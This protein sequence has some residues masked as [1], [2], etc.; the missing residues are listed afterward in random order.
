MSP[1]SVSVM[2]AGQ[3]PSPEAVVLLDNGIGRLAHAWITGHPGDELGLTSFTISPSSLIDSESTNLGEGIFGMVYECG[4]A[5]DGSDRLRDGNTGNATVV[6]KKLSKMVSARVAADFAV[7]AA[8]ME[9]L[10]HPNV[11]RVLGSVMDCEP[12]MVIF[13]GHV[14]GVLRTYLHSRKTSSKLS[15]LQQAR[16]SC[17]V[18]AGLDYLHES[19]SVHRD[20]A[21]RNCLVTEDDIVR[22]GDFGLSQITFP[23]DYHVVQGA[24]LPVRWMAPESFRELFWEISCHGNHPFPKLSSSE[25]AAKVQAGGVNVALKGC[26]KTLAT[27]IASCQL[28]N[29]TKRPAASTLFATL[30]KLVESLAESAAAHPVASGRSAGSTK[31][32]TSG[33]D[34]S[35][36]SASAVGGYDD[37]ADAITVASTSKGKTSKS[38]SRFSK[39]KS[40]KKSFRSL[41]QFKEAENPSEALGAVAS[42][43]KAVELDSARLTLSSELGQGAFGVVVKGKLVLDDGSSVACACKTLKDRKNAEDLDALEAE[44]ELVSQ[45]D[46]ENVVKCFGKVT[47]VDPA[48]IVFEFMSNGSLYGYLQSLPEVPKLQRMMQ[49]AIDVAT[50]MAYLAGGNNVHRDLATR[51]VLVNEELTCKISDFGLSRDLDDDTY[52]ESDG[53]MVP[54]RWTPPEAYKYKK[55]STSS[56]VWSYG[57]TLYEVWTKGGLPYGRKW[58]NMNVMIEVE[59]GYRLPAPAKCPKAVYQ[60]MLKCWNPLRKMRPAFSSIQEQLQMAYDMMFPLEEELPTE[61]E[62][63]VDTEYGDMDQMYYGMDVP[64][65]EDLDTYL[66]NPTPVPSPVKSS[67]K[68]AAAALGDELKT[69]YVGRDIEQK[70]DRFAH[71]LKG[72]VGT[73][74]NVSGNQGDNPASSDLRASPLALRKDGETRGSLRKQKAAGGGEGSSR[75]TIDVSAGTRVADMINLSKAKEEQSAAELTGIAKLERSGES[76]QVV[77]NFYVESVGRAV[78]QVTEVKVGKRKRCVCR[79]FKCVCGAK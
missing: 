56:D 21:A 39:L 63:E 38:T 35:A 7:E 75:D 66:E 5:R 73:N 15:A 53:G 8:A 6:V 31:S 68:S 40:T 12:R 59:K 33:H 22:I 14:H 46:H 13:E 1:G 34:L 16:M 64:D 60:L 29:P 48:M 42:K 26:N 24:T 25:V 72:N 76:S 32:T 28:A 51:N 9:K 65:E 67:V 79:R 20:L 11:L 17:D 50:G 37:P 54:I 19:G 10:D 77:Q 41:M 23:A 71:L 47:N 62:P 18:A 30:E 58:T 44:A 57:I 55:Y 49:I 3:A 4:L 52:Y 27:V 78:E 45:F 43:N 74:L 69:N 2:S 70:P 36:T 61:V